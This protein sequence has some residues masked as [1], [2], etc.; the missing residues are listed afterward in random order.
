VGDVVDQALRSE[1]GPIVRA[2]EEEGG[3]IG[4]GTSN[5]FNDGNVGMAKE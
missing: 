5:G 2:V 4:K 3:L 1:H